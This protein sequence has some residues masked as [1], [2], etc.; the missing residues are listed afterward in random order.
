[1]SGVLSR[2]NAPREEADLPL[3]ALDRLQPGHC[4]P[5]VVAVDPFVEPS[6]EVLEEGWAASVP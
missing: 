2:C 1:M 3:R 5:A 4:S 6:E